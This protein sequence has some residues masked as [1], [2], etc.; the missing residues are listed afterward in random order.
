M[1]LT[2]LCNKRHK[3]LKHTLKKKAQ[4]LLAQLTALVSWKSNINCE[5][6]VLVEM[7]CQKLG[8]IRSYQF[9][10]LPCDDL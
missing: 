4:R 7:F 9:F 3:R 8:K 6:Y 2:L 5:Q 10:R 1:K